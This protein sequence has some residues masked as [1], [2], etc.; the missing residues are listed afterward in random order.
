MCSN[1]RGSLNA[2]DWG[3]KARNIKGD[4]FPPLSYSTCPQSER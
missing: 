2:D 1:T 4:T 3:W